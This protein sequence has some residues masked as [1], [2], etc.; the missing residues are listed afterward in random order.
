MRGGHT[1]SIQKVTIVGTGAVG[2]A[3]ARNLVRHGI[4]L[5]LAARDLEKARQVAAGLGERVRAVPT[6]ALRDG[7]DALFLAVPANAAAA[8]LEEASGLAAGTIVVDCTNPL[9]WVDG[10]VH[11]PPQE[12]SMA[13]HLAK[14]FPRLRLVKAFNTV[15]AEFHERPQLGSVSADLY[16]A[17]D[18]AEARQAVGELARTLGFESVDVGPLRNAQHLESMAILW[19]HL[20]SVGKRGRDIAFKLLQR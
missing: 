17:G 16:L 10:P 14:R 12:G 3:L 8:V 2:T 7:V 15:G 5:Q 11:A 20:T 1:V 18:D 9:T 4:E 6:A 19:I 13:A